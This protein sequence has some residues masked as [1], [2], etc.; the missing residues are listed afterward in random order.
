MMGANAVGDAQQKAEEKRAWWFL[1][2]D[3]G[4]T[5]WPG[6]KYVLVKTFYDAMGRPPIKGLSWNR[7]YTTNEYLVQQLR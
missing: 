5:I 1:K 2:T 7:V 3:S 6:N 4:K